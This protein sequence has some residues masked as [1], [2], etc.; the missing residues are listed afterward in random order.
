M[1]MSRIVMSTAAGLLLVG[2]GTAIGELVETP[3]DSSGV[4]H[5]CRT[6]TAIKGWH[7]FVLLDAGTTCPK[8]TMAS[9]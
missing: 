2:G 3:V 4:V 1:R 6:N 7:A 9:A 8:G 5:G